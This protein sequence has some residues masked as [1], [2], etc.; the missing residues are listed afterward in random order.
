MPKVA[1]VKDGYDIGRII[2][3]SSSN[4]NY[5]FKINMLNNDYEILIVKLF[6]RPQKVEIDDARDWEITYHRAAKGMPPKIHLKHK[7]NSSYKTLDLKK[8]LE[9]NVMSEFPIPLM[10]IFIPSTECANAYNCKRKEHILFDMAYGNTAEIYL[11]NPDFNFDGFQNKWPTLAMLLMTSPIEFF[12]TNDHK[13]T[14]QKLNYF[15]PKHDQSRTAASQY[16]VTDEI[17]L[18]INVYQDNGSETEHRTIQITFIENEMY[19]ALLGLT[20]MRYPEIDGTMSEPKPGYELDLERNTDV[21]DLNE[22]QRWRYRFE[23]WR[24]TLEKAMRN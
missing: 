1:I 5:D 21:F 16:K 15:L 18:Y 17:S 24:K 2:L 7:Q 9:P 23:R 20:P 12:A 4:G 19:F 11:T 13:N 3:G 22:K 8:M 14:S 6:D 10:K